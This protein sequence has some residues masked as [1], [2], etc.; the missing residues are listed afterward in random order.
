MSATQE[1]A[2]AEVSILESLRD[3]DDPAVRR[4]DLADAV[5]DDEDYRDGERTLLDRGAIEEVGSASGTT[6]EGV[7][8]SHRRFALTDRGGNLL[9]RHRRRSHRSS[10]PVEP[11]TA[12]AQQ[13]PWDERAGWTDL[14]EAVPRIVDETESVERVE[15]DTDDSWVV[16]VELARGDRAGTVE[17][18]PVQWHNQTGRREF[19]EAYRWIFGESPGLDDRAF[20]V[21]Q[22]RWLDEV[23]HDERD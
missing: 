3:S 5:G 22:A 18:T 9:H 8:V 4:V 15:S 10:D 16:R 2:T 7:S 6:S 17:F 11:T 1:L 21:L 14:A 23:R 20:G 13:A 19:H 12:P